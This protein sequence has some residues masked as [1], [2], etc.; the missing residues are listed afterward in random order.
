[1]SWESTATY[2]RLIN[3][4]VKTRLGG[5]HSAELLLY[6]VDMHDIDYLQHAGDW[7]GAGALLA[8][9]ARNL[10]RA[11]ADGLLLC[12][13]T[14][15]KVAQAIVAAVKIPLLHIADPTA[16]AVRQTGTIPSVCLVPASRWSSRSIRVV[17]T[18]NMV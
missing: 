8:D 7:N 18:M 6:S 15:H 13:N 1:M 2:Y 12:T 9:A 5:L 4:G 10:E 17:C 16:E 11:G 3:E 14:M